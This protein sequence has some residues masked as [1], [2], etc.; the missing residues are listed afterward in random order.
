[1]SE[2]IIP[3]GIESAFIESWEGW[4]EME[5]MSIMFYGAKFKEGI[6]FPTDKNYTVCLDL[7][8]GVI[9]VYADDESEGNGGVLFTRKVTLNILPA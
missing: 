5:V 4:D 7:N 2:R 6:D 8:K 9:E 3:T 1:M